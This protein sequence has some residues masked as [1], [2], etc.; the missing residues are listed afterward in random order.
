[1][2]S[3]IGEIVGRVG[4][5]RI[6][7]GES[8][9][10]EDFLEIASEADIQLTPE[11]AAEFLSEHGAGIEAVLLRERMWEIIGGVFLRWCKEKGKETT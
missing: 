1:M 3:K 6:E 4:E 2:A 9:I 10:L 11:E 5:K 8:F 7:S